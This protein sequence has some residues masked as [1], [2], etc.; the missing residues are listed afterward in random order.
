MNRTENS[1]QI[2]GGPGSGNHN[3]GQGR[4]IGKPSKK[5]SYEEYVKKFK[6]STK[7]ER[8]ELDKISRICR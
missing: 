1:I 8:K 3:P 5:I 2:N 4:G 6:K 7:T